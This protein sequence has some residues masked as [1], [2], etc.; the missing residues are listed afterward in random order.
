MSELQSNHEV[1]REKTDKL[2]SLNRLEMAIG[3]AVGIISLLAIVGA[4]YILPYRVS[5]LENRVTLI[6]TQRQQDH[7]LLIEIRTNVKLLLDKQD[8]PRK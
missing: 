7:D 6:E 2:I 1:L 8:N 3:C 5:Q 4:F